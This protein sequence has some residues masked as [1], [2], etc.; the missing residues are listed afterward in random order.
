MSDTSDKEG[1]RPS[2]AELALP[3]ILGNLL[4]AIVGM[5]QTKFVGELGAESLAA[6]NV[7]QRMFFALQAVMMAVSAGTTALVARAWGAEDYAEASRVT[8]ASL[9]LACSFGLLLTI[10][11]IVFAQDVASIFGLSERS[12]E[13]AGE[14]IF[15]LSVFNVAFGVNFIIGAALRAAG[16]AWTPLWIG[17]GVNIINLA[18][19]YLLVPGGFGFPAMGAPGA[20][21][22]AGIAFAIGSVVMTVMW[23][24]QLFVVRYVASGWFRRERFLRLLDVGYPAAVEMMVFQAGFVVFFMLV[25]RYY[26][27]EAFAAYGVGA[28]ILSLCMVVGFGFSI[29]GSTLVGQHLGAEDYDGAVRAGWK[30]MGYAAVAMGAIGWSMALSAEELARFFVDDD[31]RTIELTAAM[32]TIM[33]ISTPLLAAEFAIGGALRGAGDTRFPLIATIIGLLG[34]RVTLAAVFTFTGM[35][36]EWVYATMVGDYV[37]KAG[38]LLWRFHSGRWKRVLTNKALASG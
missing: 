19:L 22:A 5:V 28:M 21:L 31:P 25:G 34:V 17:V 16:D 35:P 37:V 29:A 10:P 11:G 2:I 6:V 20:A 18:A 24:K 3:S 7:G 26:G 13:L 9:L 4:F 15:W 30:A 14:Y 27:T 38:M 36:V 33:G 23:L 12:V 8:M 32:V 1:K